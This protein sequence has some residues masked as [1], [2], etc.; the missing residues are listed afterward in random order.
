MA[1]KLYFELMKESWKTMPE[2]APGVY[3]ALPN[4]FG[5]AGEKFKEM[6]IENGLCVMCGNKIE[7]CTCN[8][9]ENNI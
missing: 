6:C 5:A 2:I 3:N 7:N 1:E 8:Q 9:L 4:F